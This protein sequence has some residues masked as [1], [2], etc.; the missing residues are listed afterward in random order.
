[1]Q[2]RPT[3]VTIL[4]ILAI[5]GGVLGLCGSLSLFGLGGLAAVSG[6]VSTGAMTGLYGGLGLVSSL[7]YLAFGVGAWLLKPWAWILGVIAAGLSVVSNVLS[8]VGGGTLIAAVIGLIIPVVIL[9]YLFRPE[10]KAAF[11]RA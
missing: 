11:G 2:Q 6:E 8:L 9:W 10:I 3:G 1:M 4:A 5:I 7:I